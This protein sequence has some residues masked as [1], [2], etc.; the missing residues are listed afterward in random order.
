MLLSWSSFYRLVVIIQGWYILL[1]FQELFRWEQSVSILNY[2]WTGFWFCL[3]SENQYVLKNWL[4]FAICIVTTMTVL[5]GFSHDDDIVRESQEYSPFIFMPRP[6]QSR[7]LNISSNT[8]VNNLGEITSSCLTPRCRRLVSDC[9]FWTWT[10][11]V[12]A[13][14]KYFNT[15]IYRQSTWHPRCKDFNKPGFYSV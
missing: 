9:R 13:S 3:L 4:G 1:L 11:I 10:V 12:A 14:Y 6:F 8:A 7:V 15:L 2:N 5:H